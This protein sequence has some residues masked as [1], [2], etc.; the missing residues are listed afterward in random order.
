M[1]TR[2]ELSLNVG[3]SEAR[4][5]KATIEAFINLYRAELE[6]LIAHCTGDVHGV[7]P[8][9]FPLAR[10]TQQ[11]LERLPIPAAQLEDLYPLSPMQSGMLFHSVFDR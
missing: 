5:E 2:G 6:A 1:F 9:D 11:E 3:Y 8:S 10:I 7:T 4:Y